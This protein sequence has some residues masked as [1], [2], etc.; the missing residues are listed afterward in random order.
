MDNERLEGAKRTVEKVE[1]DMKT[2]VEEKDGQ[3]KE[4]ADHHEG[5]VARLQS[6][7]KE[8][9]AQLA[10]EKERAATE[11]TANAE[12]ES[13]RTE[14]NNLRT[15]FNDTLLERDALQD[16]LTNAKEQLLTAQST[17]ETERSDK[18]IIDAQLAAK[19]SE[20]IRKREKHWREKLQVLEDEKKVMARTLLRAWGREDM[21]AKGV[22]GKPDPSKGMTDSGW[23]GY[24]Y[25]FTPAERKGKRRVTFA[26]P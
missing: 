24:R 9:T 8:L 2:A 4:M 15:S 26:E 7:V 18:K 14:L 21:A 19:I 6:Q 22:D 17:L 25:M 10:A 16:D 20:G 1:A 3:I 23:Q 11:D 12:V 5:A 13:L